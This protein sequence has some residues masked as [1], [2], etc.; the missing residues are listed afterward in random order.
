MGVLSN[1]PHPSRP[2]ALIPAVPSQPVL[3]V[4]LIPASCLS[5]IIGKCIIS[6]C[7]QTHSMFWGWGVPIT[8]HCLI[9]TLPDG[10]SQAGAQRDSCL[11]IVSRRNASFFWGVRM[12][13][14]TDSL[15]LL[16][17]WLVS[18]LTSITV[19]SMI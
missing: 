14:R 9:V 1:D 2:G 3:G 11:I 16:L 18:L 6:S 10:L 17:N 4:A 19:S 15:V 7:T 8:A 12:R 5:G 13:R